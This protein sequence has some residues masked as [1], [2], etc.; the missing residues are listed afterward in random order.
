MIKIK[1]NDYSIVASQIENSLLFIVQQ[2]KLLVSMTPIARIMFLLFF[3]ACLGI[4]AQAIYG[5]KLTHQLV[6]MGMFVF[7]IEQSRMAVKD[8]ELVKY[9]K[10]QV[11]DTRVNIFYQITI[12][13]IITELLG[14]YLSSLWL[15]WGSIL[16][17]LS[18]VWFNL[19]ANIRIN[20]VDKVNQLDKVVVKSWAI[21]E[22]SPVLIADFTGLLLVSLWMLNIASL[23]ISW[24]LF[25][26]VIVY[27]SIKLTIFSLQV[28]EENFQ[29]SSSKDASG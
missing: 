8:L 9:A 25:S 12:I 6:A 16:I 11:K 10:K 3:P 17:L 18:Q 4:L 7:C 15:G 24:G 28:I 26:M 29:V 22:R 14:F 2:L 20:I 19:F 5:E 23:W 21:S 1:I 13:T 27:C